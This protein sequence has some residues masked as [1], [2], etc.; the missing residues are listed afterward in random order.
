MKR[1]GKGK[2]GMETQGP[3]TGAGAGERRASQASEFTGANR[4]LVLA[5]SLGGV[6][7]PGE[8]GEHAAD[9]FGNR[10]GALVHLVLDLGVGGGQP[11]ALHIGRVEVGA[12]VR[13]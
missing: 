7:R 3:R 8:R 12:I 9:R 5:D 6:S 2:R 1:T 10:R 4:G 11:N 13:E